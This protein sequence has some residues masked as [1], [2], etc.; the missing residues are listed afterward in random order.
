M[1]LPDYL[2]PSLRLVICGTAASD[3]AAARGHHY[4]GPGRSK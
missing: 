1:M 3:A 4:A 2:A